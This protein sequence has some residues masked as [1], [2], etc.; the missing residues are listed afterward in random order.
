MAELNKKIK[1]IASHIENPDLESDQEEMTTPELVQKDLLVTKRKQNFCY[2][3]VLLTTFPYA[4]VRV[5]EFDLQCWEFFLFFFFLF[6][7]FLGGGSKITKKKAVLGGPEDFTAVFH[8]VNYK[9]H[10][11]VRVPYLQ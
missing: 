4:V 11:L 10:T 9:Y 5:S 8:G 6:F 2:L 1:T 7:F 3:F